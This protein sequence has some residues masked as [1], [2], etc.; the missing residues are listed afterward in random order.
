MMDHASSL[1]HVN[2]ALVK[3]GAAGVHAIL[4]A[5]V[6]THHRAVIDYG[7]ETLYL[8]SNA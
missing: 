8:G 6:L 4:G 2:G 7:G 5:D 1:A 3:K